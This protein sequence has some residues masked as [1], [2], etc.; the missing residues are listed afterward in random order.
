MKRTRKDG[1][2]GG[3]LAALLVAGDHARARAEARRL[4]A[5]AGTPEPLRREA[6][7]LL[8]ALGPERG[9]VAVGLFGVALAAAIF[10]WLLGG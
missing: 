5:D 3:S 8:P 6:A 10:G 9:A 1:A 4:L 7:E 2:P